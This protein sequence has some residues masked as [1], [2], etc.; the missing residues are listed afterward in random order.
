MFLKQD[1]FTYI[2]SSN[3]CITCKNNDIC[4][5]KQEKMELDGY[6]S[7][8]KSKISIGSPIKVTCTCNRYEKKNENIARGYYHG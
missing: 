7:D 8:V 1:S 3:D 4:S 6:V 2:A 5:Y